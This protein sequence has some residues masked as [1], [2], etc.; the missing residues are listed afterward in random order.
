MMTAVKPA[1]AGIS[2]PVYFI[3]V[4]GS[5]SAIGP[6]GMDI[7]LPAIPAM[8]IEFNAPIE[9]VNITVSSFLLGMGLGQFLGGPISDQIGR[10]KVG[11]TGLIIFS[12]ASAAI[13]SAH[14]IDQIIYLRFLQA[15]GAGFGGVICMGAI[16]DAYDIRSAGPKFALMMMIMMLAPLLSPALGAILLIIGWE[17]IFIALAVYGVV[18]GFILAYAIPETNPMPSAR[19]SLAAIMQQYHDVICHRIDGRYVALGYILVMSLSMAVLMIFITTSSFI[20]MDYFGLSRNLFPVFF[21]ANIVCAMIL[22]TVSM[23][24]M[25]RI[26]P[27]RIMRIGIVLQL[28]FVTLF[29]LVA[30]SD[31]PALHTVAPLLM[32]TLGLPGLINPNGMAIYMGF[33][34]RQGG[35]ASAANTTIML[36]LGGLAGG[37]TSLFHDGSLQPVALIMWCS[38]VLALVVFL[39]L[40]DTRIHSVPAAPGLL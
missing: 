19:V 31:D 4:I 28:I 27:K 17:L 40:P 24:L 6:L 5:L 23:K 9:S 1:G 37:I 25:S 12:I 18:L 34:P 14:T 38:V 30:H 35:S 21:G 2:I 20:Y 32:I 15:V 33:F 16:R 7:Y 39:R 3:L 29:A 22:N 11:V 13:I 36:I 26:E 8:V 10:K